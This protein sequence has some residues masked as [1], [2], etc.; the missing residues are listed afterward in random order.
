MYFNLNMEH[1]LKKFRGIDN[2]ED[3]W[4]FLLV[5]I[6][7]NIFVKFNLLLYNPVI[8]NETTN[9]PNNGMLNFR[10][11]VLNTPAATYKTSKNQM[12]SAIASFS[13]HPYV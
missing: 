6:H 1:D 5:L 11:L 8:F 9:K 12:C 4:S 10:Y 2:Q 13:Q 3:F 7:E